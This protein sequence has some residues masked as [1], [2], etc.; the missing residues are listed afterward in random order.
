VELAAR[1]HSE[2]PSR[3]TRVSRSFASALFVTRMF[4]PS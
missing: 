2:Y 1:D 4:S 3:Y